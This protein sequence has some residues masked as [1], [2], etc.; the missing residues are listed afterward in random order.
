MLYTPSKK[1]MSKYAD[2][3]VNYALNS[4]KG[5]KKG[6]IV[7]VI[8]DD[9]AKPLLVALYETILKAGGHPLLRMIP[10]GI[11]R[12]F[13][14]LANDKQ[15]TF[16]PRNYIKARADLI[17]HQIVVLSDVDPH[18]L[19][20]VNPKKIIKAADSRKEARKWF[21]DKENKGK[22]TWTLALYGTPA[23][24]KEVGLSLK[25][26]WDVIIKGCYLDKQNPIK[27]W[28]R[29]QKE[30]E[31]VK[32]KLNALKI[33]YCHVE[34][35]R[36]NLKVKIG[37]NRRWLGGSGRNIPSFELFISPDWR[38]VEGCIQFNEPL[39][40]YGNL[41]KD[42][43]L[44][45]KNGRVVKVTASKNEKLMKQIVARK[46]ADKVGEF[47]LTDARLSRINHF[48]ANTLFDE[49][50]GGKYGNTHVAVGMAYKDSYTG[51]PSKPT[52]KQW[53]KMGFNDSGE[54]CD[55]IQTENR[56]VT[57]HL[58]NGKKKVIYNNGKFLV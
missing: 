10:T 55:I 16:F 3:L 23:A 20:G 19:T 15:L 5:I 12:T 37:K 33:D 40:R 27:E 38:G 7:Q 43:R 17:D 51:D 32:K 35:K 26:Y 29:I 13:Y 24:A 56:K 45:F 25:G 36:T 1:V 4:G 28:R 44:E 8:A 53:D 14:D 39:Y 22:F 49:N 34:G 50:R 21:N 48:M 57:A 42:V 6:D 11:S 30:Q 52:T 2:L 47:S 54:H 31:R 46:N 9:I 41:I 18:E 58:M